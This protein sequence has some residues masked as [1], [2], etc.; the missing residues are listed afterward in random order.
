MKGGFIYLIIAILVCL[1]GSTQ[2]QQRPQFTQ[3]MFNQFVLNPAYAGANEALSLTFVNRS[4]WTKV[5]GAPMTQ[6]LSG[7]T[8]FKNE[9]TGL[10]VTITNDKVGAHKSTSAMVA[11][12]Y[13]LKV[14]SHSWVSMGIQAGIINKRSNF[15]NLTGAGIDPQTG[16]GFSHTYL[17][18]GTGFYF[19]SRTLEAGISVPEIFPGKLQVTDSL[20]LNLNK[21]NWYLFTKY[22]YTLNDHID[23]EPGVLFKY[24][25][26]VPLSYDL[27][28]SFEFY[29][30]FSAGVS[31]RKEESIDIIWKAQLTPQLQV[32]YAYDR[33]IGKISAL[34]NNSHELMVNYVFK[35]SKSNIT[36]PR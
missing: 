27:N 7:H 12:T 1:S 23:M 18:L 26:G 25:R 31:Y 29:K 16:Q 19:R 28:L 24:L 13:H 20:L 5:D 35:Y 30:V 22:R 8:L 3:Y 33:T 11:S 36:S 34:S 10:G 9:H 6:T 32:G 14:A 2:A 17:N 15:S 4:Q 21:P